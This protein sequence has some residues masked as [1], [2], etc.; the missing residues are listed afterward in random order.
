MSASVNVIAPLMFASDACVFPFFVFLAFFVWE[1][2]VFSN[3]R[4]LS[5]VGFAYPCILHSVQG[6]NKGVVCVRIM[7]ELIRCVHMH[8][9]FRARKGIFCCFVLVLVFFFWG[10]GFLH[11][12][13][14]DVAH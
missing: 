12:L 4:T 1:G 6:E 8:D 10:G 14:C 11:F 5:V 13:F 9:Y 2:V 3:C 7:L